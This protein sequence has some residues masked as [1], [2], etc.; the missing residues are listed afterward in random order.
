MSKQAKAAIEVEVKLPALVVHRERITLLKEEVEL[1]REK[2]KLLRAIEAV[3]RGERPYIHPPSKAAE[4]H[5]RASL[6]AR[7]EG[8]G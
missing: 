7:G 1:L 3:E 6:A 4:E 2:W 5:F 8:D